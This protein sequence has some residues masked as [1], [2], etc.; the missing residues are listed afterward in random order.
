MERFYP[1]DLT[2]AEWALVQDEIATDFSRGGRPPTHSKRALLNAIFYFL[3]TGCQW[4]FLPKEYPPWQAVYAQMRRWEKKGSVQRV[5][6]KVYIL[7][8]KAAGKNERAKVG[9][10]DSQSAKTTEKG[11]SRVSMRT[12]RSREGKGI[13]L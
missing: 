4:R 7:A 1:S 10:V 9:I 12:R 5:Y 2:D 3:R 6:E 13:S 8:R 11:A